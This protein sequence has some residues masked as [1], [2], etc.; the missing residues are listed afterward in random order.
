[1]QWGDQQDAALKA[2]DAWYKE[3]TLSVDKRNVKQFFYL[4]GYAG[5]GKTTLAKHF[6]SNIK[7]R[8]TF[9]AYTGKASLVMSKNGCDG[10]CTIHRLI[11]EPVFNE[12]TKEVEFLHWVNDNPIFGSSLIIIDECSMI[13]SRV[14]R[15]LLYYK[16]P[17]L[18]LG[19]P[20]QLPPVSGSGYFTNNAPDIMLTDIHRQAKDNPII[21]LSM[22]AREGKHIDYGN[23]G[24]SKVVRKGSVEEFANADQVLI[25]TNATRA[26]FNKKMRSILGYEANI[27]EENE[28]LICLKNDYDIG[29]FNGESF[30]MEKEIYNQGK[31]EYARLQI[32]NEDSSIPKIV[33]VH[34]YYFDDSY[35]EPYWEKH[36]GS[37]IPKGVHF[38][39]FGYA[40][41]THKAQGSQWDNVYIQDE[42]SVF[43]TNSSNW[44]YTAITRGSEKLTLVRP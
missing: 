15:D 11:Y 27:P 38:F 44:L 42:S 23:Y 18:V 1:M 12:K 37:R 31:N 3:Y 9:G 32:S 10:A 17:V 28:K 7:G 36:K 8:V 26:K 35:A 30:I 34:K 19:D 41:T 13:D 16:I 2:V 5:T 6:A 20:A 43:R 40:I 22:L 24:D 25:G 33:K 21:Y 39:D 29:I 14:A 4:G